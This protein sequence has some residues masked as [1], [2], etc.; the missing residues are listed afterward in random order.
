MFEDW[1]C[2][3]RLEDAVKKS[4]IGMAL[5][6]SLSGVAHA[7]QGEKSTINL[8][9]LP[10]NINGMIERLVSGKVRVQEGARIMVNESTQA[11][12]YKTL[13]GAVDGDKRL[14]LAAGQ[15]L[16][17]IQ[18]S[19]DGKVARIGM[20]ADNA[21]VSDVLVSVED[22]E[23]KNLSLVETVAGAEDDEINTEDEGLFAARRKRGGMTYCYRDVKNTLLRA[24]KC[25]R[26]AS[27]V[28]AE[29][30]YSILANECG[31]KQVGKVD[32]KSLPAYSVCVSGGGRPCGGG[33]HCGHIAVK[34]PNGMWFGA[35][36][37]GTPYLPN[38]SKKGYKA[39]YII[40]CLKPKGS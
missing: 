17:I 9:N 34:L 33:T 16:E 10:L 23:A 11:R 3:S 24:K 27:G 13:D 19:R 38:S 36:T 35:G 22:L 7:Q 6:L 8:L 2:F 31:M 21:S 15:E 39:R 26:Y 28:R 32:P 40:G 14:N 29:M 18:I 12:V 30:G 25:G 1:D 20:D 5:I 4:M 37:R